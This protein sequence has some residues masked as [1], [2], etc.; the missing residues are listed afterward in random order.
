ML[1]IAAAVVVSLCSCGVNFEKLFEDELSMLEAAIESSEASESKR[2]E[3]Q[4]L[5][6]E[7]TEDASDNSEGVDSYESSGVGSSEISETP[8]ASEMSATDSEPDESETP[9]D[10]SVV[11]EEPKPETPSPTPDD[12]SAQ[13]EAE[14][15][16]DKGKPEGFYDGYGILKQADG[17]SFIYYAQTDS[18]YASHPYAGTN[19][20]R[21]GCGPACMAM[22]ISNFTDTIIT[23]DKMGDWSTARGFAVNGR[24]SAYAL[25]P[26]A[27]K[28]YGIELSYLTYGEREK[29]EQ[30]LRDGK[31][32]MAIV[33]SGDFAKN[34]HFLLIR[35]ITEDGKLLVANSY[36]G[37]DG[38]VA[39][40]YNR[41]FG[42]MSEATLWVFSK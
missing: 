41:V 13:I 16:I 32:I 4:P 6:E 9:D 25:F 20:G 24:G 26:A 1:S 28:E 31:L 21:S 33:G 10:S 29:I 14:I 34:R 2:A 36:R 8:E 35:G 5:S 15:E 39:W 11:V 30:A 40:D 3:E 7:I 19:I 37:E 22:V 27:C 38:L 17:S 18:V 23:P 42:Q 12:S